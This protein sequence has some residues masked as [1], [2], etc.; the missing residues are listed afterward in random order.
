MKYIGF[1]HQ[2]E[3]KQNSDKYR[4]TSILIETDI[5]VF[6]C[7]VI[8]CFTSE[9]PIN[10]PMQVTNWPN[11]FGDQGQFSDPDFISGI[12]QRKNV[13]FADNWFLYPL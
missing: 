4:I 12:H 13:R 6:I 5:I 11:I 8:M 10:L 3:N 2:S 1:K 7:D 9:W